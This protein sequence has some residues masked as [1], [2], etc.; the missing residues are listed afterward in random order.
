MDRI[1]SIDLHP[2]ALAHHID[3]GR[4]FAVVVKIGLALMIM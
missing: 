3:L 4:V 2:W 1:R